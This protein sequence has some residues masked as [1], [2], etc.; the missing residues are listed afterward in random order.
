M[1]PKKWASTIPA[2]NMVTAIIIFAQIPILSGQTDA[3]G[4]IYALPWTFAAWPILLICSVIMFKNGDFIDATLNM[5]LGGTLMGQNLV[6]G[7]IGLLFF[8][9][10]KT[11]PTELLAARY[12]IDKWAYLICGSILL[13]S[14]WMAHY[15]SKLATF[16][17]CSGSVGFLSLS[18]MFAGFGRFF[19]LIGLIG[20]IVLGTCRLYFGLAMMFNTAVQKRVFPTP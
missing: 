4:V 15:Q 3:N 1:E 13:F 7:I 17:I 8:L 19:G 18:A 2:I 10:D 14:A 6:K 12:A 9:S 20:L 5:A 16:C 11:V